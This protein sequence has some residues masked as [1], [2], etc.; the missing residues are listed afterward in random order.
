M[1]PVWLGIIFILLYG[2]FSMRSQAAE[3]VLA[4]DTAFAGSE[5]LELNLSE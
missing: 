5:F 2:L 3:L 1:K 4:A